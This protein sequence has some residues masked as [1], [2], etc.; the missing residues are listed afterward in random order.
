MILNKSIFTLDSWPDCTYIYIIHDC[1]FTQSGFD[2]WA[3]YLKG[4]DFKFLQ[5]K[6]G[7]KISNLISTV[8]FLFM[9]SEYK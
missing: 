3:H 7:T 9:Y 1:R 8:R 6:S 5:L 2:G 4:R